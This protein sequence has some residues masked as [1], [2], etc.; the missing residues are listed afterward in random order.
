MYAIKRFK[1]FERKLDQEAARIKAYRRPA[2]G[3]PLVPKT[4][5][6]S[7]EKR[8]VLKLYHN[9]SGDACLATA[10]IIGPEG[11][12]THGFFSD[13][14]AEQDKPGFAELAWDYLRHHDVALVGIFEDVDFVLNA[15][16]D[17]CGNLRDAD[18]EGVD[19]SKE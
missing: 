1:E 8:G 15:F 6:S 16:C 3:D 9:Q 17:C 4:D 2:V 12:V 11:I 18:P 14:A 7:S 19:F 5:R 10:T 13:P